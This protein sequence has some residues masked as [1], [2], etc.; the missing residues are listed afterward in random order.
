MDIPK[1]FFY[2]NLL[3]VIMNMPVILCGKASKL[4]KLLHG[5]QFLVVYTFDMVQKIKFLVS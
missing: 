5:W 2:E 4:A 1:R 3:L